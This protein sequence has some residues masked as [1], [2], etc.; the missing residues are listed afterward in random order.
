MENETSE[1]KIDKREE[2]MA[3]CRPA[4]ELFYDLQKLRIATNNR[5]GKQ[6]ED[7]KA[8]LTDRDKEFIRNVCDKLE[9]L[10]KEALAH[11]GKMVKAYPIYEQWMKHQ[12]G[13]GPT[14]AAVILSTIDIQKAENVSKIWKYAGID[15]MP[16]GHGRRPVKGER[17]HY[18]PWLKTKL[19]GVLAESFVRSAV[20]DE[21]TNGYVRKAKGVITKRFELET[22]WRRFYDNYKHR[23]QNQRVPV[24]MAC[25]G[26]GKSKYETTAEGDET[27]AKLPKGACSNCGG[28]GKDAPWGRSDAHRDRAAKRY[29]IKMFLAELYVQ[30]RTLEGLPVRPPYAEEYLN[31]VHHG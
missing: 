1:T 3:S 15:V 12:T 29:M 9:S 26:T 18:N 21:E 25:D 24:C 16:N 14:M 19:V 4:T 7:A 5:I 30:W 23:K 20:W 27:I 22:V 8:V 2:I 13:L 17:I 6:G 28:R 31:R 11:A 10:E